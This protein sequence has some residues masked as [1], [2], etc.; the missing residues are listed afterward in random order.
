MSG[1]KRLRKSSF[2]SHKNEIVKRRFKFHLSKVASKLGLFTFHMCTYDLSAVFHN[3]K[4]WWNVMSPCFFEARHTTVIGSV[5]ERCVEWRGVV[6]LRINLN[7]HWHSTVLLPLLP[8]KSLCISKDPI[9]RFFRLL[10]VASVTE[11][12]FK[13][14]H[15]RERLEYIFQYLAAFTHT[16]FFSCTR[17]SVIVFLQCIWVFRKQIQTPLIRKFNLNV[18]L[19]NDPIFKKIIN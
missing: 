3:D 14:W 4:S 16:L 15:I 18:V 6:T 5:W 13:G 1:R 8:T 17:V 9:V 19:S 11:Q 12:G 7:P 10:C 2:Y